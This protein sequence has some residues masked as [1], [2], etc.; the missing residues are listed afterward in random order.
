MSVAGRIK[1][2]KLRVKITMTNNYDYRRLEDFNSLEDAVEYIFNEILQQVFYV[3]VNLVPISILA[4][5]STAKKKNSSSKFP[6][7]NAL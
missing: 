2:R 4:F 5:W 7:E 6:I 3:K 1:P